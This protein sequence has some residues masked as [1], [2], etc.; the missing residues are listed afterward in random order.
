MPVV[1]YGLE[2]DAVA[3]ADLLDGAAF[4]LAAADAFGHP[5]R[6]AARVRVPG[7]ACARREMNGGGADLRRLAGCSDGVDVDGAGE[8][9]VRAGGRLERVA[10]D[11]HGCPFVGRRVRDAL[12]RGWA[13]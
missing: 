4:T 10:C 9:I 11:L 1:L 12:R 7:G 2:E 13:R 3:G 5:D 8:P 6:L